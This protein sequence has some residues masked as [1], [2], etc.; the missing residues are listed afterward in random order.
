M[1]LKKLVSALALVL[2]GSVCA[3][4]TETVNVP[5]TSNP[6]LAGMPDGSV[7]GNGADTAPAESPVQ[8]TDIPV[9]SGAVFTFSAT[10]GESQGPGYS[11]SGP[12]G[13]SDVE[14]RNPQP[15][16]GEN[17]IG[18]ITSPM[19]ALLGVFLDDNVPSQ[20]SNSVPAA[21]DFST[22]SSRDFPTLQP[23]LRQPFFIGDGLT[24]GGAVQQFI[25][26]P[27]ATRPFLGPM[28]SGGWYNNQG[29]LL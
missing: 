17:G 16:A 14:S 24:S 3:Q 28:D 5:G 26:P 23:A 19:D 29:V 7:A 25:A 13:D 27:G 1:K 15:F 11:L 6:W 2:A 20:F 10:G 21:L 4:Q 18:D 9:T 12:D 8:V 22:A